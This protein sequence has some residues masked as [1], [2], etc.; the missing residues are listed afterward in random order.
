MIIIWDTM[1][2]RLS[3]ICEHKNPDDIYALETQ[4][5]YSGS[6]LTNNTMTCSIMLPNL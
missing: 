2:P 5:E 3:D 1:M 4:K 6:V